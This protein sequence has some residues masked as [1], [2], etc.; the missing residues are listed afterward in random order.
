MVVLSSQEETKNVW[1]QSIAA[2][3][4]LTRLILSQFL[5]N[6][7]GDENGVLV[8]ILHDGLEIGVRR[9][10]NS[11]AKQCPAQKA[12]QPQNTICEY[13]LFWP[14]LFIERGESGKD[15]ACLSAEVRGILRSKAVSLHQK[16]V[17]NAVRDGIGRTE[18]II[19]I[20]I[21]KELEPGALSCKFQ[22][23]ARIGEY[24]VTCD[25]IRNLEHGG[26]PGQFNHIPGD[27]LP[28]EV[29]L[30]QSNPAVTDEWRSDDTVQF[31]SI[32]LE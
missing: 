8:R 11:V 9:N 12:G 24:P 26:S 6:S 17:D 20:D 30:N 5:G 18:Q 22:D 2:K 31:H 25:Q 21:R 3:R 27:E 4:I 23:R 32:A 29:C 7:S 1:Y 14:D 16:Q 19:V 28:I 13:I 15:P 10:I